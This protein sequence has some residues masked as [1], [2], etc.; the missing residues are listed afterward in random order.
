M[1]NNSID[2]FDSKKS[3]PGAPPK[4]DQTC[5]TVAAPGLP[6]CPLVPYTVPT[7]VLVNHVKVSNFTFYYLPFSTNDFPADTHHESTLPYAGYGLYLPASAAAI[8]GSL[9]QSSLPLGVP[10]APDAP[11][12]DLAQLREAVVNL[13]SLLDTPTAAKVP[14][15]VSLQATVHERDVRAADKDLPRLSSASPRPRG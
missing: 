13:V 3:G 2:Y 5:I 4:R 8:S 10:I 14:A 6:G 1:D 15:A 12:V 11:T 9:P 7:P